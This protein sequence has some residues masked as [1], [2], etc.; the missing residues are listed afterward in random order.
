M[1]DFR[2]LI[3]RTNIQKVNK[4]IRMLVAIVST[5]LP[6]RLYLCLAPEI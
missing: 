4:I 6:S 2:F 3:A 5:I 1:L